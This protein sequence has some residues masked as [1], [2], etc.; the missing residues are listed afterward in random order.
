MPSQKNK[1]E[2]STE[3]P[4]LKRKNSQFTKKSKL[5]KPTEPEVIYLGFN[6]RIISIILTDE[7]LGQTRFYRLIGRQKE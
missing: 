6:Y 7:D 2:T 1:K 3:K 5:R 4:K